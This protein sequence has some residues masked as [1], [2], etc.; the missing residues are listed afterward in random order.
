MKLIKKLPIYLGIALLSLALTPSWTFSQNTGTTDLDA[1][2]D[3]TLSVPKDH[4]IPLD[5]SREINP[6]RRLNPQLIWDKQEL[7]YGFKPFQVTMLIQELKVLNLI[8]AK[9]RKQ[10]QEIAL[11]EEENRNL[12]YTDSLANITSRNHQKII[13][14]LEESLRIT[15][16]QLKNEQLNTKK[17]RKGKKWFKRGFYG[18]LILKAIKFFAK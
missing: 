13:S 14:G 17:E 16:G 7:Y 15:Q 3:T 8:E 6:E 10:T 4:Q 12:A 9:T 18:V 2:T 1:D 11:L 5:S